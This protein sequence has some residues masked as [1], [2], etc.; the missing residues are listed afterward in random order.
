MILP[1]IEG[2]DKVY[3]EIKLTEEF[4]KLNSIIPNKSE[5]TPNKEQSNPN[6]Q[7]PSS[8]SKEGKQELMKRQIT[9]IQSAPKEEQSGTSQRKLDL[10]KMKKLS[11]KLQ[12]SIFNEGQ[13]SLS[14]EDK[15]L[16]CS[17]NEKRMKLIRTYINSIMN[18][19][20]K[21]KGLASSV[22]KFHSLNCLENEC[23]LLNN[24]LK[25][26]L[27]HIVLGKECE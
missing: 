19:V 13:C 15:D 22:E 7:S 24:I 25:D 2:E 10:D 9:D 14:N 4:M 18:E 17:D 6:I 8:S 26:V 5:I 27:P 20:T 16:F 3:D 12:T 11:K 1:G 21:T 23:I